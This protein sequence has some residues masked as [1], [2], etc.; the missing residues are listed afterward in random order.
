MEKKPC[1]N[2]CWS[3][4][5]RKLYDF[6]YVTLV[7]LY[8]SNTWKVTFKYIEK[9][10]EKLD[11]SEKHKEI[12]TQ[13]DCCLQYQM[14]MLAK[15]IEHLEPYFPS[16]NSNQWH[17]KSFNAKKWLVGV[18]KNIT[19]HFAYDIAEAVAFNAIYY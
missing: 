1:C 2:K 11:G 12:V 5:K 15:D 10:H 9:L 13:L 3:G 17:Y 18:I 6:D 7:E 4:C 8:E 14:Y 16:N 19:D